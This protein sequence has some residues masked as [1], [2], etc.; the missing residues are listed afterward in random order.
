MLVNAVRDR[1]DENEDC[2]KRGEYAEECSQG[3]S[4]HGLIRGLAALY[5]DIHLQV[6][7]ST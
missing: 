5:P 6:P 7:F 1:Y 3:L 2:G 4:G